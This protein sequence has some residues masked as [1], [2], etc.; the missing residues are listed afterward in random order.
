[1]TYQKKEQKKE[2]KIEQKKDSSNDM[3]SFKGTKHDPATN[4]V[5]FS[6]NDLEYHLGMRDKYKKNPKNI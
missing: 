3:P 2:Q 5:I 4:S 6:G 1:M